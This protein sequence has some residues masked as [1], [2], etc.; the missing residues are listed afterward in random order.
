MRRVLILYAKYGGGHLSAA[1]SIQTY[2]EE[3]YFFNTEAKCVDCMEYI[4]PFI[5]A[6][7]TDAY[8]NMAKK[9]PKLWKGVKE[10][11]NGGEREKKGEEGLE[12][13][14]TGENILP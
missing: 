5:S 8:K 10:E 7:T 13:C 9:T 3:H 1:K 12:I 11:M 14:K 6:I 4:N 2:I